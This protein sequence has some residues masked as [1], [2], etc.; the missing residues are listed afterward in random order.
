MRAA[1]PLW[2]ALE[3]EAGEQLYVKTGGLDFGLPSQDT[4]Q[5]LKQSMDTAEL[6][7]EHLST[8]D[9][10]QRF[11]QLSLDEG[12][13]GLFQEATGLLKT[14]RCVLAH[15]RL[16]QNR[17]ATVMDQTPVTKIVP[18]ENGV[19]VHTATT[20]KCPTVFPMTTKAL[21][22]K[23]RPSTD[24]KPSN[25]PAKLTTS[26]AMNGS[27][28]FVISRGTTFPMLLGHWCLHAAVSIP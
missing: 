14:S 12:M 2:F 3:E 1:Y 13:E 19:E 18:T 26:P 24:G 21:V 16:A 28:A 8:D 9:V 15:I 11:P 10:R 27:N 25:I 5:T 7:Y 6:P 20:V 23:S 22:T 4:F 17:G